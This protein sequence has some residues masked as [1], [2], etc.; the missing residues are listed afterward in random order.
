MLIPRSH[1]QVLVSEQLR[2]SV[3]VGAAHPHPACR[4]VAKVVKPEVGDL[5]IVAD[6][7]DCATVRLS[8]RRGGNQLVGEALYLSISNCAANSI[9]AVRNF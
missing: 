1:A 5:E 6:S 4:R 3:Y 9:G 8:A 7:A 2:D